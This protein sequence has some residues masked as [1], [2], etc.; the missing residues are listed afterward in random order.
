MSEPPV[1]LSLSIR[2]GQATDRGLRRAVN[3]DSI[4]ATESLFAVADGMGGHEAGEIASSL[5]VQTLEAGYQLAGG[6]LA[7]EQIQ[8]LVLEADQVVTQIAAGRGGTTLTGAAVV[9]E[10]NQAHWLIF[11]VGDS[12]TYRLSREGLEQVTVDHS[13]VQELV[14]RGQLEESLAAQHPR[15]HVITRALGMGSD[16]R[17][18]YWLLPVRSEERLL[19]CSDGLSSELADPEIQQILTRLQDPQQAAE[20]LIQAAL[21]AGGRDNVSVIVADVHSGQNYDIDDTMPRQLIAVDEE[22]SS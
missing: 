15:R 14:Q 7:A 9:Y 17:A 18:D 16:N 8:S 22:E 6:V 20:E 3:E 1:A 21:R 2:H 11:N 13:E 4:L 10:Q 19:I 12:R 5:C